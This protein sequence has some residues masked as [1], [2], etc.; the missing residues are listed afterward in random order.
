M[1]RAGHL[2]SDTPHRAPT[3]A[4]ALIFPR[5]NNNKHYG[6]RGLYPS[7]TSMVCQTT[8]RHVNGHTPTAHARLADRLGNLTRKLGR[9]WPHADL[10]WLRGGEFLILRLVRK[11]RLVT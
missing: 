8:A 4:V 5:S 7:A 1:A 10:I 3:G 6:Q 2:N 9:T 11:T